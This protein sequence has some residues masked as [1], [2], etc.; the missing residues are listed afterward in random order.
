MSKAYEKMEWNYLKRVMEEMGL[1]VRMVNLI[2]GCVTSASFFILINETPKGH[3][4]SNRGLR[5]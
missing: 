2:M 4:I 5:Q 3:I 1:N